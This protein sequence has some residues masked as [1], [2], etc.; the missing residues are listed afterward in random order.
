M[1]LAASG[2]APE[3]TLIALLAI[4]L[5]PRLSRIANNEEGPGLIPLLAGTARL[6]LVFGLLLSVGI[7]ATR[8]ML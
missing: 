8:V 4:P 2:V 7:V 6:H 1:V 5:V 3:A